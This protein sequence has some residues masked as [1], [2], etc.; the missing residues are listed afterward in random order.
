MKNAKRIIA[1]A[2]LSV[3]IGWFGVKHFE[4]KKRGMAFSGRINSLKQDAQNQLKIGTKNADVLRFFT[5]H[6]LQV[7]IV[8]SQAFGSIQTDGCAPFGCG[9]DA[10]VISLRIK[11]DEKGNVNEEPRIVG[12]YTNCL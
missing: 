8:E 3:G 7:S 10:A 1:A 12:M 11:L 4:C 9:T 2:A 5:E 6:G